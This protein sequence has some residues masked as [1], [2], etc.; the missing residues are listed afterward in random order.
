MHDIPYL[1]VLSI[2]TGLCLYQARHGGTVRS[3]L[4]GGMLLGV[5]GIVC[6]LACTGYLG[7][8][9]MRLSGWTIFLFGPIYLMATRRFLKGMVGKL[10]VALGLIIAAVA[11]DAFVIEPEW[12][13]V[14]THRIE[15]PLIIHPLRIVSLADIQTD[16]VGDYERRA[17]QTAKDL[18]PDLIVFPGDYIQADG[19]VRRAESCA[20]NQLLKDMAFTPRLGAFAVE[21]DMETD[22]WPDLFT[23][24]GIQTMAT[25][26]VTD[27]GEIELVGLSL[28]ASRGDSALP[29]KKGFRVVVGHAPDFA[30]GPMDADLLLAGHTHG[31][32]VKLPF[33]GPL[34][35]LSAVPRSWAG[36]GLVTLDGGRHLIV[37]RGIGHERGGAP[38]LRFNCRPEI[39]V[40]DLVPT[41]AEHP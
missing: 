36:G 33:F 16:H 40:I 14:T 9:F 8:G 10:S 13:T 38:P 4:L 15:S 37:S 3:W 1:I 11:L 39:V 6:A 5:G 21:G 32:Q 27:L 24:T 18:K 22:D 23:N 26:T 31:G 35:T 17:L 2:L 7:F 34:I 20:F 30:L 28:N 25:N 19:D 12:L 29:P 41:G